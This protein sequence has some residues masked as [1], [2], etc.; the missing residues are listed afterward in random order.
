MDT[1]HL[2][3]CWDV[4]TS[5]V[6]NEMPPAWKDIMHSG[7][8]SAYDTWSRNR[9]P[10]RR[11]SFVL[12]Y[13]RFERSTK[14]K[15]KRKRSPGTQNR[16]AQPRLNTQW[17]MSSH[18]VMT[19]VSV[20]EQDIPLHDV[21]SFVDCARE[22]CGRPQQWK[23]FQWIR[24]KTFN[25][26]EWHSNNGSRKKHNMTIPRRRFTEIIFTND[27]IRLKSTNRDHE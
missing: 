16:F 25:P 21:A 23:R 18:E 9:I 14:L 3:N 7:R 10:S 17:T 27:G 8:M 4:V 6:M 2:F 12:G 19:I 26:G 15:K 22:R 20:F 5:Y 1:C 13:Q 11:V 24:W